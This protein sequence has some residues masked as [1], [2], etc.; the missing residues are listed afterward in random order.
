[1]CHCHVSFK[2]RL[3]KVASWVITRFDLAHLMY[4]LFLEGK[5]DFKHV[6]IPN[7]ELFFVIMAARKV[8]L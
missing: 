1:M 6:K 2:Y 7:D 3:D 8:T 5:T 4:L